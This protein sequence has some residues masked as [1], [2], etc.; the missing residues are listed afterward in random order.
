MKQ[1]HLEPRFVLRRL[2]RSTQSTNSVG[3][4]TLTQTSETKT[5]GWALFVIVH[6]PFAST[7]T[8]VKNRSLSCYHFH[9]VSLRFS[10]MR[11]S[12]GEFQPQETNFAQKGGR[13][14]EKMLPRRPIISSSL[15]NGRFSAENLAP[16]IMA[17]GG[18]DRDDQLV[19]DLALTAVLIG[20]GL[21]L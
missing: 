20:A 8:S 16:S 11:R 7:I 19:P 21:R 10:S 18:S 5:N 14:E 4:S 6:S 3:L 9:F 2:R 15:V 17:G 1:A 12:G 13:R